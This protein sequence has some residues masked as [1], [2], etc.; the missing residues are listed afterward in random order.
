MPR[1]ERHVNEET[2]K[3]W[4]VCVLVARYGAYGARHDYHHA[5]GRITKCHVRYM[6]NTEIV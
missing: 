4:S 3:N 5:D 1:G 6:T 2:A